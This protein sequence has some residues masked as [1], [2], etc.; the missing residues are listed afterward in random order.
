MNS[1]QLVIPEELVWLMEE[2]VRSTFPREACGLLGGRSRCVT[3]VRPVL[4]IAPSDDR[5]RMEPAGQV[6][7]ILAIEAAGDD[8]LAIYH[9]HPRGPDTPSEIDIKQWRYPRALSLIWSRSSG[10]WNCR[11]FKHYLSA[12]AEAELIL[13]HKAPDES[14]SP[15]ANAGEDLS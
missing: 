1:A 11:A 3:S 4:N 2:H 8:L 10:T 15:S 13:L 14:G 5:F 12:Y 9:S 6:H 7:A